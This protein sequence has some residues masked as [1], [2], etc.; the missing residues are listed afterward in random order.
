MRLWRLVALAHIL[1]Y[2][3]EE[4]REEEEEEEE[5]EVLLVTVGYTPALPVPLFLSL[6]PGTLA[7]ASRVRERGLEHLCALQA[8]DAVVLAHQDDVPSRS[9]SR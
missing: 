7:A 4:E 2:G 5:E 6:L 1:V 8:V 3:W 9:P